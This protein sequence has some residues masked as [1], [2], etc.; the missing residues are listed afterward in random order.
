[1]ETIDIFY[2]GY[3]IR[4]ID[5]I[6]VHP[7]QTVAMIKQI[8]ITKHG[9]KTDTLIF[10][11]DQETPLEDHVIIKE[12]CGPAGAK[13]HLH[14]CRHIEVEVT[15]AGE[16]VHHRVAPGRTVARVKHWAAVIKFEMTEEEAGEH[17]LQIAGTQDRPPPGTHVGSLSS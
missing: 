3:G 7:D 14:R 2:Q 16:T 1:M 5:H 13:I 6:E 10:L 15:F 9:C 8:L 12:L 11:E 4:G 17:V